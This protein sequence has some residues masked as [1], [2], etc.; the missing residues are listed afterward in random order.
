[1]DQI[2]PA[3]RRAARSRRRPAALRL[4]RLALA[5]ALGAAAAL[6]AR[7]G[8]VDLGNGVEAVWSLNASVTSAWRTTE[9]DP[10]LVGVGDGGRASA[11]SQSP[12]LNFGK[13]SN[14]T[15]L[16]RVIG[17]VNLKRG[18]TGGVLRVKAWENFRYSREGVSFGAPS[19]GF[20]PGARLD[21]GQFDTRLSK[22]S[23]IE[24][25]DAYG[26]TSVDLGGERQLKLRLGQHAVNFG[27]SLFVPGVNAYQALDVTALRTPGTLLKEAILPVPQLS[28]NLGLGGGSSVEGFVQFGWRRT[29]FD[30]CGT[31]FSPVTALNCTDT[32]ALVGA[33][34]TSRQE[35]N[36]TNPLLPMNFQFALLPDKEPGNGGQFG[37]AFKKMVDAIDTEFGAYYVQYST[38]LP[39]L[40]AVR[41]SSPLHPAGSFYGSG[42]MP[43]ATNTA[44]YWDYSADKIKVA[45]LSASTVLGGWSVSSELSYSKDVPVQINSVDAFYALAQG[46]GPV[47]A[48][49]GGTSP[50]TMVGYERKNKTQLQLST[51]KLLSNVAG[52]SSG[53]LVG[54]IAW[55]HWSGMGNPATGLRYGRGFEFGAAAHPTFGG[56]CPA[57]ATNAANCTT[58]GY[59]TSNAWGLRLSLELEYPG[60][61]PGV[62]VKPRLFLSKDVKGWSADGLF[63]QGRHAIAPGVKFE[64]DKRYSLDLSYTRFNPNARFDSLH[65]R[66]FIALVLGASF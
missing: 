36:G 8:T 15:K 24:L 1:M 35:W 29:A 63:S 64:M 61:L 55:Q 17:D 46:V 4:H 41:G 40:S 53:S 26:Y 45:G 43:G 21:D 25:F 50:M 20:T 7:A 16:V 47:G 11:S 44:V 10:E 14:V 13:G 12:D 39:N 52:A 38:K 33:G 27:E 58:D 28:F 59:F 31:F 60:L 56:L 51:V 32:S 34:G 57:A 54:E 62:V 48:L 9:P 5:A 2:T 18:D 22:F 23:G 49:W 6:P 37:L 42:L 3:V 19:N 30:G 66:D 65:D